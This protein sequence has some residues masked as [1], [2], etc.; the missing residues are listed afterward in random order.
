MGL[1]TRMERSSLLEAL[2]PDYVRAAHAKGL[3]ARH[4][5]YRHALPNAMFPVLAVISRQ[6]ATLLGGAVVIAKVFGWPGI[7]RLA[8]DAIF[9]RD[10]L[11]ITNTVLAFAIMDILVNL[12]N[13]ILYACIDPRIRFQ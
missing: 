4:V 12:A 13:D 1:V 5:N 7:G 2:G 8:V 9:A 6:F 11:V 10:Y 3:G